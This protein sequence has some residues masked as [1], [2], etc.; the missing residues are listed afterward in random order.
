MKF[1]F[2]FLFVFSVSQLFGQMR[3]STKEDFL[4]NNNN[5]WPTGQYDAGDIEISDGLYKIFHRPEFGSW[6]ITTSGNISKYDN[7]SIITGIKQ[8]KGADIEQYGMYFEEGENIKHYFNIT[9][10][11]FFEIIHNGISIVS[12][13]YSNHVPMGSFN[14]LAVS[15]VNGETSF[16][17]NGETVYSTSSYDFTTGKTGWSVT[18]KIE[19]Q[20]DY[21]KIF[22]EPQPFEII[23]EFN[24]NA[25]NWPTGYSA[26]CESSF[27]DGFYT[28][29]REE[30]N[31]GTSCL[32]FFPIDWRE[33]FSVETRFKIIE[34]G[35]NGA[36][37][38]RMNIGENND[39]YFIILPNGFWSLKKIV[40]GNEKAIKNSFENAP[41]P[42]D[43]NITLKLEHKDNNLFICLNNKTIDSAKYEQ[44]TGEELGFVVFN[45]IT[46][47]VDYLKITQTPRPFHLIDQPGN[48]YK[49]IN[50][51]TG[52]NSIY[53]ESGPVIS[54]DG[55]MLFFVRRDFPE[56]ISK[57]GE[58]NQEIYLS[59]RDE[60]GN[61]GKAQN[62]GPPLNNNSSN[63]VI[64][65]TPDMNALMVG[66][67]YTADG[68]P[69]GG[70]LSISQKTANGSWSVPKKI[71]IDNF[72]NKNKYTSFALSPDRNVMVMCIE[73]EESLGDLDIYVSFLKENNHWTEPRHM[74]NVINTYDTELSPFIAAD[75]K[76]MYFSSFGHPGY[77][78][79][80]VFITRR[81]DDT[82]VNW[83]VPKNMGHE[84]NTAG[85][86]ANFII[87]ASGEIAYLST[88]E[89]AMG[90]SDIFRIQL[91]RDARP[92]MV[93]LIHGKV[94]NA[95]TKEPLAASI[96][97]RILK[98]NKESGTASSSPQDGTYKIA[99]PRGEVYA[100]LAEKEGFYSI[101]DNIDLTNLEEYAEIERDLFLAPIEKGEVIRLNNLFFEFDKSELLEESIGELERLFALLQQNSTMKIEINGH[102]DNVGSDEYNL[103]LS[104]KRANSVMN[105][106]IENGIDHQRLIAKGFGETKP[107]ATNDTENGRQINR[108]VEFAIIEK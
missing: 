37:G 97:Y 1:I 103:D 78:S 96:E 39:C 58:E 3:L 48:G 99:L 24:T 33:N 105:Y 13:E 67:T 104:K 26:G 82:W 6:V 70:G 35:E 74:G 41:L 42:I 19:V 47:E 25:A 5:T 63:F 34:A 21:L 36:F 81:L 49:K 88:E 10:S 18:N 69:A 64:S 20:I 71:E 100:F 86:D 68:E 38:F 79:A 65:V 59:L 32:N 107:K 16:S 27:K 87:P 43:E 55:N 12:D 84:I 92:E 94:L 62:I 9:S 106:L 98:D 23:E 52:V 66:N 45:K 101:S 44:L 2:P 7:Y 4:N 22:K 61:W 46:V 91:P 93:V 90:V 40:D 75:G 73:T 17:I 51:G 89:N 60:D 11:G 72:E 8:T 28:L 80:D 77:G 57:W 108:R 83:S 30:S 15:K 85:W 14:V 31:G 102:T 53:N 56:I 29:K 76:T 54:S 50:L 95:K